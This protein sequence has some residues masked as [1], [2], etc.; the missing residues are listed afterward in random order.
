[1]W[2]WGRE[3]GG[4]HLQRSKSEQ[5][6]GLNQGCAVS[7]GKS[8]TLNHSM[9]EGDGAGWPG[10]RWSTNGSCGAQMGAMEHPAKGY[11]DWLQD[12]WG[13]TGLPSI[14]RIRKGKLLVHE[15]SIFH[16]LVDF[17]DC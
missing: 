4:A 17:C 7:L 6:V 15:N 9:Y 12:R 16:K 13:S 10:A 14:I 5:K 2:P 1:M 3:S 8:V 11:E